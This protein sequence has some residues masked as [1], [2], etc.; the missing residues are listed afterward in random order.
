MQEDFFI[1]SD[2][3]NDIYYLY[4]RTLVGKFIKKGKKEKALKFYNNIKE[5]IKLDMNKKKSI[6]LVF[7]LSM[8]NSM[9][10]LS[11]KEMRLG[12]QKKDIPISISED[13][14]VLICVDTLLKLSKKKKK[15]EIDKLTNYIIS[16]YK[17]EGIVIRNKKLTYKKAIINRTFLNV[18]IPKKKN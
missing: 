8:L 6:P 7:L 12:S 10:K 2:T 13:K 1:N 9:P 16:S 17:N 3:F 14:Q 18:H 15:L 5:K 4:V 11:F